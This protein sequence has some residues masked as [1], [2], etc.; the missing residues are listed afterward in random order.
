MKQ[1]NAIFRKD[2]LFS[3]RKLKN[4]LASIA[5]GAAL[6]VT[7]LGTTAYAEESTG[8]E[9]ATVVAEV[10]EV[11]ATELSNSDDYKIN[12]AWELSNP[13]TSIEN[14]DPYVDNAAFNSATTTISNGIDA[15]VKVTA[16]ID[17]I[18]ENLEGTA[19]LTNGS[20]QSSY[21]ATS[22]MFVGSPNPS[23]IPALGILTQPSLKDGT[24]QSEK[25]NHT[26]ATDE[27]ILT[28][29]F[30]KEVTNPVLD[31]SGLGGLVYSSVKDEDNIISRGSFNNTSLTLLTDNITLKKETGINLLVTKKTIRV[32]KRN[33][34]SL[35]TLDKPYI[36]VYDY[37]DR[38][39]KFEPAGTGS[40]Q[41][42][43][44]FKKVQF[45]LAHDAV[46]FSEFDAIN[47][48][49]GEAYFYKNDYNK[50]L[51]AR[52]KDALAPDGING[53]NRHA[54]DKNT[55]YEKDR[56]SDVT[57][58]DLFRISLR[59]PGVKKGNVTV[60]HQIIDK[61]GNVIGSIQGT[62]LVVTDIDVDTAYSTEVLTGDKLVKD[63][64]TYEFVKV[65]DQS[66]PVSGKVKEETQHV[67]YQYRE[68]VKG[69]VDVKYITED[70][71]ILEDVSSVK[72]DAPVGEDYT[73]E[74]KSFDGYEFVKMAETSAP[75]NGNVTEADQ[76]VIYVYK[77]VKPEVKTGSVVAR[78]VIEGTE[79]KLADDKTVKPSETPVDE[80][81]GDTPPTT[82]T[83]DG[84][85][86]ELVRTRSNEGDAP[87][88]G[89]VKEGVQT[90]T[91]EYKEKV[92]TPEVVKGNVDVKYITEDGEVLEDVSSV[93]KD[94]PVGE[95]YATEQK[96]F[97]GYE[98]VKMD[99]ASAPA[100]GSVTEADQHVIYVYK[101]VTPKT[102]DT[103]KTPSSVTPTTKVAS[104]S[105]ATLP[106]TGEN[107]ANVALVSGLLSFMGA[108][109]LLGKK[110]RKED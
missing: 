14:V 81:Y 99:D 94:A 87:Q 55:T 56:N 92:E 101:K 28:I 45:K 40:I 15:E 62:T 76:H 58:I 85:T 47:Y 71:E 10:P 70:G 22:E 68:V 53:L 73:T 89:T 109:L 110:H 7:F 4:G 50:N 52:K 9:S 88:E 66:A 59:I 25:W 97:D 75:T 107:N 38:T 57:N 33:T 90:I 29:T 13:V 30:N 43:G 67:I 37:R 103:P 51:F 1:K 17:T 8:A 6:T 27:A 96:S 79:T 98:F 18:N 102:P 108:G 21:G 104:A 78:Y 48:G 63:G 106:E 44:K 46:P 20:N 91:Y 83:K 65:S 42:I 64:K 93:K 34:Y 82:I 105:V 72:S 26:G 2:N 61:D 54:L 69:N 36:Q 5:V 31:I 49:T 39:P 95:D 11:A 19:L 35:A 24:N 84:K 86:Y 100:N 3:L 60:E 77:K 41:L 23:S 16:Q 12:N 80:A 74:Q 32:E